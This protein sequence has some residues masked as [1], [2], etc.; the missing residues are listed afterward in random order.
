MNKRY[1]LPT[2]ETAQLPVVPAATRKNN[3][4]RGIAPGDLVYITEGE[5]K[6]TVTSVFHYNPS[7]DAVLVANVTEKRI[8]PKTTW[9]EN[10]NSHYVDYPSYLP[11]SKVKL[12]GKDKDDEG[13]VSY[14]VADEIVLKDKYYDD[15]YKRWLPKRFVKHHSSI[16]IPWP[17]PPSAFEDDALSTQEP[18]VFEKTYEL[19][20][21]AK[22][23]VPKAALNQL[24]NPYS[25]HK[26][27]VLSELQARRL[28]SP[29]M[30]LSVEQKIYLAKQASKPKKTYTNLSEEIK[31]FIGD[32]MAQHINSID[33]PAMLAHLEALSRAKVPDF[34]KTIQN[35]ED[36]S[37]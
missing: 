4:E 14:V 27:R 20:T 3:Y 36:E 15:R 11:M 12:A 37:K 24:R 23:P 13:K 31:D 35:I 28:N 1:T 34:E 7:N 10:Q 32:K 29:E 2:F 16:E 8:T 22:A 18:T 19:Q 30:P 26:K 21:I 5:K 33:N 6:G 9:V 17:N 25:K